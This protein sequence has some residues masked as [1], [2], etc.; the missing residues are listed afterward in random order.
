MKKVKFINL[1]GYGFVHRINPS[2]YI[3][4]SYYKFR[5]KNVDQ[6]VWLTPTMSNLATVKSTLD[7]IDADI[8]DVLCVSSFVWNHDRTMRIAKTVK[9][10]YPETVVVAGGP[11]LD[12]HKNENFFIEYPYIDYVVYGDGEQAFVEILDSIV[13]NRSIDPNSKNAVNIVTHSEKF[14]FKV[15][16]DTE[17]S[18]ISSVLDC[19]QEIAEEVE[20][21]RSTGIEKIFFQWE[22]ARGCPYTCSFCDWSSGLHNKVKRK[23]SNWQEE[24]DFLYSLDVGI[25]PTDANWGIYS[26]DI[27][28]T[29]YA[30][31][32]GN[33]VVQNV[34]KLNKERAFE[35]YEILYS[36]KKN[37]NAGRMLKLSFQDLNED[38]LGNINRPEIPWHEHKGFIENFHM[39]FPDVKLQAEIIIGLPG[40]T[41][42]GFISQ[43]EKFENINISAIRSYFWEILPN[44]PAFDPAY[45]KKFGIQTKKF[46][47]VEPYAEFDSITD[48][49][50]TIEAGGTGWSQTN[51]VIS[52]NSV[53]LPE[54]LMFKFLSNVYSTVGLSNGNIPIKKAIKQI[55]TFIEKESLRIA[56]N[57]EKTGLWCVQSPSTNKIISIDRYLTSIEDIKKIMSR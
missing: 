41:K 20:Y 37:K 51:F 3:L 19:K 28:I 25:T 1:G 14:P 24:I 8:P 30:A 2:Y 15:F 42:S 4:K 44:S 48:L 57:V 34:A 35:V 53:S 54:I 39:K 33:F 23:K 55:L 49:K 12:A 6:I 52:N 29:R 56:K 5:G 13:E 32:R 50:N 45:Q 21:L 46:T 11:N 27:E 43:L 10:R 9:E 22:R 38:V 40:Q 26:D 18:S 17:Y 7:E 16:N 47:I 36:Q 31:A